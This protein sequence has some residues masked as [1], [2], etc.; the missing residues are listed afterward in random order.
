MCIYKNYSLDIAHKNAIFIP[1]YCKFTNE[2]T[3]DAFYFA[4][5]NPRTQGVIPLF[6]TVDPERD[7]VQAV[8]D[9]I[10]G[11]RSDLLHNFK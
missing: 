1:H 8:A 5:K 2:Y 9:Y 6:I 4:D 10:K 3:S 11:K 7:T